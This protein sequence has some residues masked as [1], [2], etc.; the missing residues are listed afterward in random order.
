MAKGCF[1]ACFQ[2]VFTGLLAYFSLFK[3]SFGYGII[4]KQVFKVVMPNSPDSPD[5]PDSPR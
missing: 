1:L 4:E 5:S 3:W 2:G